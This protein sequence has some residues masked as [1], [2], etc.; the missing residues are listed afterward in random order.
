MHSELAKEETFAPKTTHLNKAILAG[1]VR[2]SPV[3]SSP[4]GHA[5][6]EPFMTPSHVTVLRIAFA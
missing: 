1:A 3:S 4:F 6:S 5:N 2:T